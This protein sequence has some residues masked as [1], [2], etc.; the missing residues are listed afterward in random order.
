MGATGEE[1]KEG[2]GIQKLANLKR[3]CLDPCFS[4][5]PTRR[6]GGGGSLCAF[7]RAMD[8]EEASRVED[9]T[10]GIEASREEGEKDTRE[11]RQ[12]ARE[13]RKRE[14]LEREM[15]IQVGP[16]ERNTPS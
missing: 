8:R 13:E 12:D 14:V 16:G 7:R 3:S 1:L 5:R 2:N 10:H 15:L 11:D 6:R 9:S 4:P